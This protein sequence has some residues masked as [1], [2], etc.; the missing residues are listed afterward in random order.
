MCIQTSGTNGKRLSALQC[1]VGVPLF[2][3]QSL[4]H[5]A[6]DFGFILGRYKKKKKNWR[7]LGSN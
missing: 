7:H 1:M 5:N 2:K 3:I 6:I 4:L